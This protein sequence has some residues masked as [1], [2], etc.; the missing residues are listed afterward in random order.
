MVSAP[1]KR[2]KTDTK[3]TDLLIALASAKLSGYSGEKELDSVLLRYEEI[4]VELSVEDVME[5]IRENL[6]ALSCADLTAS[7]K[8]MDAIKAA[9]EPIKVEPTSEGLAKALKE[10][11]Y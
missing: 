6:T 7:D 11:G 2:F 1:G 8:F 3:V 5:S 10:I 4:A 9:G